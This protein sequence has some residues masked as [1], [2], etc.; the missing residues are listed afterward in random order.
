VKIHKAELLLAFRTRCTLAAEGAQLC[1]SAAAKPCVQG[2]KQRECRAEREDLSSPPLLLLSTNGGLRICL[3]ERA[4]N[5][6][7]E[8]AIFEQ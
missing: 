2:E 5:R 6:E 8:T 4:K 3:R 7:A 1:L